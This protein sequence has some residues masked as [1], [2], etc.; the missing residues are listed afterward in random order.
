MQYR[1]RNAHFCA[2]IWQRCPAL[3]VKQVEQL[4]YN[5]TSP[6]Y[7]T[8]PLS[9]VNVCGQDRIK[10]LLISWCL[11]YAHLTYCS[12]ERASCQMSFARMQVM[13][14]HLGTKKCL[15]HATTSASHKQLPQC[16]V[17]SR[18]SSTAHPANCNRHTGITCVKFNNDMNTHCMSNYQVSSSFSTTTRSLP[19]HQEL[20]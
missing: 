10:V 7:R 20:E 6:Q 3:L 8:A 14:N 15:A 2:L 19:L 9:G 1:K 12:S 13:M 17:T 18:Q 16:T 4:Y 5:H 11:P